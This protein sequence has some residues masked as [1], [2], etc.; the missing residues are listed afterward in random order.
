MKVSLVSFGTG[1]PR[2]LGQSIDMSQREQ[3]A[4]VRRCLDLGINLFDTSER[5]RRSEEILGRALEGVP[6]DAYII[7]TKWGH[8]T[9][10]VLAEDPDALVRSTDESLRRLRTDHID[11]MQFH[12]LAPD[13][14]QEV[15]ERFYP[16]MRR[17]QEQGKIRSIGFSESFVDD[18]RH[19]AAVMA[20]KTHPQLWDTIMLKYGILNQYAAREAL[21]LALEHGVGII[22][23]AAVRIKLPRP[24]LLEEQIAEWRR[25]GAIPADSLPERDPLGWLV[26]DDVDSVVSAGYRFAADH[27][28]VS[29]VLT[30]TSSLEHLESNVAALDTPVLAESD[31]RRLM[32]LFGEVA[33]NA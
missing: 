20:L 22:N 13:A 9:D 12:G 1:G 16:V 2:N 11:V 18:P 28:A 15:V 30:G 23:M 14:Y 5:Y 6:R 27:P 32:D 26:H 29:T 7:A 19:E 4:L 8:E 21:P 33:E 31:K 17:L 25:R 3:D 24:A 10:G